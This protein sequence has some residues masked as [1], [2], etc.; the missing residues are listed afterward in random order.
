MNEQTEVTRDESLDRIDV[1]VECH[2]EDK[3]I[4]V[5]Q[6]ILVIGFIAAVGGC[7]YYAGRPNSTC[8][9]SQ[10]VQ[11]LSIEAQILSQ[12]VG[13]E[14]QK[15]NGDLQYKVIE[16]CVS[17]GGVPTFNGM[18]GCQVNG[19]PKAVAPGVTLNEKGGARN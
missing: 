8:E 16:N 13:A 12:K 9:A 14:Q 11:Q 4:Y 10:K 17:R 5:A 3:G 19:A 6:V 2:H 7:L 1:N 18:V 15:R